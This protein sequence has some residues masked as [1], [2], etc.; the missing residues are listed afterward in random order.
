MK[1]KYPIVAAVL[2]FLCV[3]LLAGC[4]GGG[5]GIEGS[6]F[7]T[8]EIESN[9]NKLTQK[10]LEGMGISEEYVI[11]GSEVKYTCNI[12]GT[13]K[14]ITMTLELNEVGKNQYEF[15]LPGGLNF[16]T[17]TVK[18]NKMSYDVGEGAN[19]TT[20]IFARK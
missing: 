3:T 8:E 11:T 2:I 4:T 19:C 1:R 7:L 15:N 6:W 10:D 14:P 16:A 20:M 12:P 17:A 18:G 9:G 5:H 13:Q